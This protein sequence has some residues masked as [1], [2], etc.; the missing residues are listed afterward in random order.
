V[1]QAGRQAEKSAAGRKTGSHKCSRQD[2]RQRQ[3]QQAG[4]QAVTSAAGMTTGS[5][6]CSRQEDRQSQVQQAGRQA[7]TS[8]AGMKTGSHKC[9]RQELKGEVYLKDLW[10]RYP[11][12]ILT[13]RS[14]PSAK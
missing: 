11:P 4:Q 6:K 14:A 8:A 5:D 7:V 2:K 10:R 13:D 9:S 3:M 1:Q 12:Q